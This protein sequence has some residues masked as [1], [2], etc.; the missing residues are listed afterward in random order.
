MKF[1]IT[2]KAVDKIREVMEKLPDVDYML[3]VHQSSGII[4]SLD[5]IYMVHDPTLDRDVEGHI[6]LPIE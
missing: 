2:K 1:P 3:Q 5:L 4:S 6:P